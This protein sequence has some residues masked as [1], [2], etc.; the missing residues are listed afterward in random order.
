M[1]SPLLLPPPT[2]VNKKHPDDLLSEGGLLEARAVA[3]AAR[4][5]FGGDRKELF[6]PALAFAV[7]TPWGYLSATPD[8]RVSCN[9]VD[10]ASPECTFR[11]Q[12]GGIAAHFRVTI[13]STVTDRRLRVEPGTCTISATG[14]RGDG[15]APDDE[16][17]MYFNY[18]AE[19]PGA[20]PADS[21][22][23]SGTRDVSRMLC[24]QRPD[25]LCLDSK[26]TAFYLVDPA[27]EQARVNQLPA[28]R[29]LR[30]NTQ[31]A[32]AAGAVA[33]AR[34]PAANQEFDANLAA[35]RIVEKAEEAVKKARAAA[36]N[37]A[38]EKAELEARLLAAEKQA[39]DKLAAEREAARK[40][41]EKA[42]VD[43]D[44]KKAAAAAAAAKATAEKA[45][46]EKKLAAEKAAAQKLAA[47]LEATRKIA[48]KAQAEAKAAK[49]KAAKAT[50]AAA[51]RG[52]ATAAAENAA[53]QRAAAP[54]AAAAASTSE[55]GRIPIP[56]ALYIPNVPAECTEKELRARFSTYGS[57]TSC[58][59]LPHALAHK[60]GKYAFVEFQK[61]E[62]AQ[63]AKAA[64]VMLDKVHLVV[65]T[66]TVAPRTSSAAVAQP[67]GAKKK[68]AAPGVNAA[69]PQS[70]AFQPQPFPP[71][72]APRGDVSEHAEKLALRY[73]LWLGFHDAKRVGHNINEPDGG[74]DISSNQAVA[75]VK[76][77]WHGNK[78]TR[79]MVQAFTGACSVKEHVLKGNR[80]FFAPLYTPDA[81]AYADEQKMKLFS[82]TPAGQVFPENLAAK[83]LLAAVKKS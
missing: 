79:P 77:L 26:G 68:G 55:S 28:R 37:S 43:E 41:A 31:Q 10:P 70:A 57:V 4:R 1:A 8:G 49:Q 72:D 75:Q 13:R 62:A 40:H 12:K 71:L 76:A 65:K 45:E 61:E 25:R 53:P 5:F 2:Y 69:P 32:S 46:V 44:A 19:P 58:V 83:E 27:T 82:F 35:L 38:A 22:T 15:E 59:V 33:R 66:K 7:R 11:L 6:G 36:R 14:G 60:T 30:D 9:G 20:F 64:K 51:A 67:L 23:F 24:A 39:A 17:F 42:Q 80:L 48:E 50:A 52:A 56:N 78:V 47:E 74:I 73:M 29:A 21:M 3:A 18:E 34:E 16:K 81:V 63:A 54:A